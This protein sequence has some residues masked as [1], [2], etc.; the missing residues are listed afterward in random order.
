MSGRKLK[1]NYSYDSNSEDDY[2]KKHKCCRGRPGKNGENGENGCNGTNGIN[3]SQGPVGAPGPTGGGAIIPFASGGRFPLLTRTALDTT[4]T[5]AAIGFGTNFSNVRVDESGEL[6]PA[7]DGLNAAFVAPRSGILTDIWC[8]ARVFTLDTIIGTT[9]LRAVLYTSPRDSNI[10]TPVPGA[11]VPL[12][13]PLSG[14]I[15]LGQILTGEITGLLI[16]IP[17]IQG[18]QYVLI[19][20]TQTLNAGRLRSQ[21]EVTF[22]AGISIS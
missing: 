12:S 8:S 15:P 20:T 21:I 10:L 1:G 2:C 5:G 17:I 16:P 9:T 18:N 6:D 3:G 13:P 11:N 7:G 14:R 19:V 4:M 22:S